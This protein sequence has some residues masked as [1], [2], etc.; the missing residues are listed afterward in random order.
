MSNVIHG[1]LYTVWDSGSTRTG[2]AEEIL[3]QIRRNEAG[4]NRELEDMTT[5]D[6]AAA[7]VADAQYYIPKKVLASLESQDFPT[8]YDK[9]L[10]Y[11]CAAPASRVRI[12]SQRER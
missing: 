11:L 2:S 12:L 7:L 5:T 8:P 10:A 9:A 1:I 3:E 6:Y 4:E